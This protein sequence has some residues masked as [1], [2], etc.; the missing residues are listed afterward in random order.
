M[1]KSVE[2]R[3][4]GRA[5]RSYYFDRETKTIGKATDFTV[6]CWRRPHRFLFLGQFRCKTKAALWKIALDRW[7]VRKPVDK[8]L[9][10]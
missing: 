4:S 10:F 3:R 6:I 8:T 9:P 7:G 5:L 1:K 2:G